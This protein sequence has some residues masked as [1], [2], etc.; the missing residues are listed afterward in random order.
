[1]NRPSADG[2]APQ[3]SRRRFLG[4][5]VAAAATVGATRLLGA[6]ATAPARKPNI[7]FLMD[8]QHRG[9][10]L[11]VAGHPCVVTPNLDRLAREGAYFPKAY[12]SVPSCVAARASILTGRSPWGHGLL[13]YANQAK[14]WPFEGPTALRDAGYHTAMIGKN[15]FNPWRNPHGYQSEQIY[16]GLPECDKDDDYGTWLAKVAP[17]VDQHSTGLGWN[18]R[19]GKPWPHDDHLHP[20]EWTGQRAVEFLDGYKGDQPY[21]LKVSFHR[22]HSPF[23][24][25]K[26][27]FDHYGTVDLPRPAV[28]DWAE[29]WFG[30]YTPPQKPAAPR[31]NLPWDDV[32][33]SRQ[34]YYGAISH[35]DEQVGRIL[36]ALERRG[37]LERTL[38]V[39]VSDHGEMVGD[40]H[41]F[42]KSYAMEG[43]ARIPMIV[44]WGDELLTAPRGQTLPQLTEL[45]DLVPTFLD[46][47]GIA[48]PKEL[49]GRSLLD[50]V[51]GKAADWRTQLDL[52]HST[53]YFKDDPWTGLTDGRFK[54]VYFAFDGR[55]LLFDLEHDPSELKDLSAD[56][57]HA[58]TLKDWRKRMADHLAERGPA[59]VK[60]GELQLRKKPMHYGANFPGLA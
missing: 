52:E 58:E 6:P 8:D 25:V 60:D 54:Y 17:G 34:G 47:A 42:R 39:F 23:D 46:A 15:H 29:R 12:V 48:R 13:G 32:R 5:G 4:A 53:V 40:H 16:D 21:F 45:R 41:L 44:R 31:A 2:P 50:P 7:L 26:R 57:A 19:G 20:T 51:R 14:R 24:P 9:D 3:I 18:D 36:A 33:N 38:I 10:A 1:M 30:H 49:E 22:P 35:V 43:S 56:P 55:Q 37:D 28:G 59:W 11:G 27:W